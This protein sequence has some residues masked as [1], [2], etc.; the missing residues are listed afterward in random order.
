[1]FSAVYHFSYPAEK[2]TPM[3]S[4]CSTP[5][6][7]ENIEDLITG[8]QEPSSSFWYANSPLPRDLDTLA[9]NSDNEMEMEHGACGMASS[10][11]FGCIPAFPSD[12][13]G[14]T[15]DSSFSSQNNVVSLKSSSFPMDLS[16]Y[17]SILP[18]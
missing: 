5:V 12:N 7:P 8:P 1:M 6:I 13:D 11:A 10:P 15:P 3:P 2:D 9:Y 16:N 18:S 14:M 4:S 17:V